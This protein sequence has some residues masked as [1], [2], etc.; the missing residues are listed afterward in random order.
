MPTFPCRA[1]GAPFTIDEPVPR[2]AECPQCHADVRA[3]VN[4]RHY[5]P[6]YHNACRETAADPVDDRRRRNFCEYFSPNRAPFVAPPGA[7]ADAARAKLDAL[8]GG[9]AKPASPGGT[10]SARENLEKLFEKK[11][12][13]GD[14]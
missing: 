9:G 14:G 3:C 5:D 10:A 2:D 11:R 8:F 12:P 7:A 6:A 1:C 13:A 4:C